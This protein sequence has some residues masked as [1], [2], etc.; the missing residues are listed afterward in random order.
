MPEGRYKRKAKPGG[1]DTGTVRPPGKQSTALARA[2][3][4]KVDET[5][6]TSR[7]KGHVSARVKRAEAKRD[8]RNASKP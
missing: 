1:A 8:A 7:V 3:Q 6:L 2:K 4:A 5:G